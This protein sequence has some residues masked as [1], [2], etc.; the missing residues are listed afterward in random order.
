M[1]IAE[2]NQKAVIG[3]LDKIFEWVK[4][5]DGT[6]VISLKSDLTEEKLDKIVSEV[7]TLILELYFTCEKDFKNGLQIFEAIVK[8]RY[9]KT[10]IARSKDLEKKMDVLVSNEMP[11]DIKQDIEQT[12]T[13]LGTKAARIDK[14]DE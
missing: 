8:E 2:T 5:S 14:Q 13:E 10:S 9:L 12:F 6:T 1:R 4:R 7:R 3:V 11:A